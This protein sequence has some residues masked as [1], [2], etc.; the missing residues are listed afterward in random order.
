MTDN[1]NIKKNLFLNA[2]W[3]FGGNTVSAVFA[4]IEPIVLARILGVT[5]F[6]LL[7]LIV[8][9]V[10]FLNNFF[11]VRVWETATKY[12]G[13]FW[14]KRDYERTRSMVKL[15]Y[16]LDISTGI[17]AFAI[18]VLTANI[19]N[20]YLIH[21]PQAYTL[22]LIYSISLLIDTANSTSDSI[23]RVFNKFKKIA[24]I[25]SFQTFLRVAFVSLVLFTGLGIKGVL[26]IYVA[27]SFIGFAI[28]IWTVSQ[29]LN[30]FKLSG[31]WR[32]KLAL[33]RDQWR[34]IAWFLTNTSFTGTLKMGNENFLGILALGYFSG[35]DAAAYYKIAR[36]A[37]KLMTRFS[38]PLH[39]AIYPE[40]V[41]ISK[42]E[43]LTD[44]INLIR[45]SL[46][47]LLKFTIPLS[48]IILILAEQLINIFFGKDYLAATNTLRVI[49]IATL[50]SQLTFWIN[51]ALLAIGKPGLRTVLDVITTTTYVGLLLILVPRFSYLGAG[52]A[53]L[54]YAIIKS[55]VSFIFLRDSIKSEEK[56]ISKSEL[57]VP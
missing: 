9:Y 34:E 52:F 35:K 53:F 25:S 15:S 31:W 41:R 45:Y 17:L 11:D 55:S 32:A 57:P 14:E 26:F 51:S 8:A 43:G 54:G 44:F 16:M 46:K 6:G 27:A 4:A 10:E 38:D 3:V 28:R 36:S 49:T 19:A 29:T 12:I 7:A 24:F 47:T 23:L 30:E 1:K 5:D 50:I 21:S 39:Q 40:L 33:I 13:T 18:A 37:V 22:I 56:R 2:S 48:I 20:K 42:S